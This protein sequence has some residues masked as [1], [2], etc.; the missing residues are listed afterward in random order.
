MSML[1]IV[2]RETTEETEREMQHVSSWMLNSRSG[3][4]LWL[5]QTLMVCWLEITL[6]TTSDGG[7]CHL[8]VNMLFWGTC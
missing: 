1:V 2:G 5:F 4:I 8:K 6:I 7:R 3:N